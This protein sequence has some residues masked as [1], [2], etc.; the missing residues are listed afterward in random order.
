[1]WLALVAHASLIPALR[2]FDAQSQFAHA[3]YES[4][5]KGLPDGDK[6]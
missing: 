3:D 2:R 5:L 4:V 6:T 1:M